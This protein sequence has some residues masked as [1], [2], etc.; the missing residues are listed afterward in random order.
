MYNWIQNTFQVGESVAQGLA[1]IISLAVVLA[2]FGLF[3]FIIKRLMGGRITQSRGRQP[4]IGLMDSAA[5]DNRRRLLLVRRD[6]IEHLILVGGPTDVVVEQNIIRNTPLAAG[7]TRTSTHQAAAQAGGIKAPLAPGPDIPLTP[8]DSAAA[9]QPH[10]APDLKAPA[11]PAPSTAMATSP[12]PAPATPVESASKAPATS[13]VP[14]RQ[15]P[16]PSSASAPAKPQTLAGNLR[17]SMGS[18]SQNKSAQPVSPRPAEQTTAP[19]SANAQTPQVTVAPASPVSNDMAPPLSAS[20][21]SATKP[22]PDSSAPVLSATKDEAPKP[23]SRLS[24]SL[25]SLARPFSPKDRPSYGSAKISPP[26]SGPA[27]RAKTALVTPVET[28][29][30]QKRVEPV[31]TPNTNTAPQSQETLQGSSQQVEKPKLGAE[32]EPAVENASD[33]EKPKDNSSSAEKADLTNVMAESIEKELFDEPATTT[34]GTEPQKVEAS[35][36]E[37]TEEKPAGIVVETKETD[38]KKDAH[39]VSEPDKTAAAAENTGEDNKE[40]GTGKQTQTPQDQGI[41][42]RNPIEAEMAKILDELGGQPKQ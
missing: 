22:E 25:S 5:I 9:Q 1:L 23:A 4:R 29:S 36:S 27:A 18:I 32:A 10:Q 26:A 11:Q 12:I 19:S 42:D 17:P 31:L 30:S 24:N 40:I 13:A 3:I 39:D 6:N 21:V 16:Q 41:G 37:S 33:P 34:T 35:A 14:Q 8:E 7:Q 15:A 28:D 2:L 38:E 20:T